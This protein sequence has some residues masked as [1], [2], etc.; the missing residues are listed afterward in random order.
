MFKPIIHV[1]A[2]AGTLLL[3]ANYVPGIVVAGFYTALIAA[4]IWGLMGLTVRPILLI[5][6]LPINL[7]TFG[8]FSFV[9]NALLFW[10]LS[11]FIQGFA[12]AGFVPALIGSFFLSLVAWALHRVL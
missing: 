6:T 10:F 1:L 9:L 7:I 5:L 12:V 11:S 2:I 8:L 4:I 3:V